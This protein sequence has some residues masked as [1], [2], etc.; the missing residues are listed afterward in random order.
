MSVVGGAYEELSQ[1]GQLG[2]E[3]FELLRRLVHQVRRSSGFPP[4]EGYAEWSDDAAYDVITSM[5]T[6]EGAGQRFVTSCFVQAADEASLERLFLA[7]IKNFL[8]D[9][10]KKT[11]R[12]KLR[13]RIARLMGADASFRRM[14]GS[15]PRWMLSEHPEGAV[16]QG[17]PDDLV[18]EAWR[19][20]GVGITRW[21]HSGPTPAQT[22]HALMVILTQVLRHARGAVREEDLAKVLESRFELLAPARSISLFVD[23]GALAEP[24]EASTVMEADAAAAGGGAA[25]IWQRLTANERQLLPYL[26]EGAHHAAQLLEVG[27]AQAEAVLA[28]LKAKLRLALSDDSDRTAVMGALL[29]RCADPPPEPPL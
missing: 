10:A 7:S 29:R 22:V 4:P 24:V 26:D 19:V 16:W 11:P 1:T 2:P 12:G 25:D 15:P 23:E 20:P 6:R 13:R 5:L 8:I 27:L 9:E 14:P 17:D 3:T 21:N 18:G 28:G